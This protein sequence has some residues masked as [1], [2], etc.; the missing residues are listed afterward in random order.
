MFSEHLVISALLRNLKFFPNFFFGKNRRMTFRSWKLS[1]NKSSYLKTLE[2]YYFIKYI[3]VFRATVSLPSKVLFI[4]FNCYIAKIGLL[5]IKVRC[6]TFKITSDLYAT[7]F[8]SIFKFFILHTVKTFLI[9]VIR[10]LKFFSC[11]S[12]FL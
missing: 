4:M 3:Y 11:S 10:I 7:I 6:T 8:P 9:L 1:S 2:T 12:F 5:I